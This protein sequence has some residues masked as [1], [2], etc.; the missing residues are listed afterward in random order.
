[1]KG[2]RLSPLLLCLLRAHSEML[3]AASAPPKRCSET[4]SGHGD[5]GPAS[6]LWFR[7]SYRG[8]AVPGQHLWVPAVYRALP[9]LLSQ[10]ASE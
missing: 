10:A 2:A 4:P 1:M 3:K 9:S 6:A 7:K 5:A 8:W